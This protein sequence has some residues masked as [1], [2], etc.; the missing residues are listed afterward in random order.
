MNTLIKQFTSLL[1]STN[2]NLKKQV[3]FD[4]GM[5]IKEYQEYLPFI[6][7]NCFKMLM[8]VNADDRQA[9]C[10][11]LRGI[12]R[13][14]IIVDYSNYAKRNINEIVKSI[15]NENE[16][17][18]II[19]QTSKTDDNESKS[20][21]TNR[22]N[23][24]YDLLDKSLFLGATGKEYATGN[25]SISEM[26]KQVSQHTGIDT[27]FV[28]VDLVNEKDYSK[29]ELISMRRREKLKKKNKHV[30]ET[31]EIEK[32]IENVNDFFILLNENLLHKEWHRRD[33]AFLGFI[34]ILKEEKIINDENFENIDSDE[35]DKKDLELHELNTKKD[36]N[37]NENDENNLELHESNTKK[38]HRY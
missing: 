10:V 1:Q 34:E 23:Y 21:D 9:G 3:A 30:D 5:S 22:K 28:K 17:S 7:K 11:I 35:N 14:F 2:K 12:K 13:E 20:Y 32:N 6:L 37:I 18:I 4:I 16:E 15:N 31:I 27:R 19:H 25:L 8:S 29:R 26:K 38:K 36:M 33:G 24:Y